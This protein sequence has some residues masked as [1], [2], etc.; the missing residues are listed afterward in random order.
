MPCDLRT[1]PIGGCVLSIKASLSTVGWP[2]VPGGLFVAGT[3]E[4]A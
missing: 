1:L 3:A 4:D 2:I